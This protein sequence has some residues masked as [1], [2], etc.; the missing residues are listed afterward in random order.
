MVPLSEPPGALDDAGS[1][2]QPPLVRMA[3]PGPRSRSLAERLERVECPAFG[4]RRRDRAR[5]SGAAAGGEGPSEVGSLDTLDAPWPIVLASA[6]G[7]NLWD[8]DGN[9]YVDLVAGFGA[10]LLGHGATAWRNA[11]QGQAERLAQGLGD[12]YASDAKI[13]LLE[14]VTALHPG[15]RPMALLG[16]SGADAVTAALKTAMLATGRP[17]V[18]AFDGAYH[19]LSFAPL[20]ACGFRASFRAPFRAALNPHVEFAPY[21]GV[22]GASLDAALEHA[23][24]VLRKGEIGAVLVEPIIGRG[25][26]VV[27][28]RAFLP[29]LR[30]LAHRYGALLVADEIWTG[31]GRS[32][33][34]SRSVEQE[35][36]PDILCFGKGLGGGIAIS[37]CVAPE[38]IMRAWGEAEEVVHTSTHAGAPLACAA[39]IVTLDAIGRR[40]LPHRAQEVGTHVIETLRRELQDLDAVTEVRGAGLMIGIE[41]RDAATA[42]ATTS[43]LLAQGYLVLTGGVH[44]EV[45]TLTPALDIDE[46]L[47]VG[48]VGALRTALVAGRDG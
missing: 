3:P 7:S 14:R 33:A 36:V 40:K 47:L 19:G 4:R 41:L 10:L 27:P 35:I 23:R 44:G 38:P 2:Q 16:Q 21:P 8:V 31:L 18:L 22:R 17:G 5:L 12:V 20:A 37:A 45:L 48:F 42:L 24:E 9:R 46:A 43:R 25:G 13:A 28:P 15:E 29:E 39:A 26:C 32:G 30:A 6:R 1:G 34:L 11:V